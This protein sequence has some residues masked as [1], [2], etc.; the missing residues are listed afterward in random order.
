MKSAYQKNRELH[1]RL[2]RLNDQI[3]L[4]DVAKL[5]RAALTLTR[6]AELKC[7]NSN[8]Y[9]SWCIER[10][11]ETNVPYFIR[12]QYDSIKVYKNRIFDREKGALKRVATICQRLGLHYYHQTDPRGLPLWIDKEPLPD[13]NYNRGIGIGE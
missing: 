11:K 13:N 1:D 5:R 7:G 8:N 2:I 6:W 10:D 9:A 3:T 12:R 4:D